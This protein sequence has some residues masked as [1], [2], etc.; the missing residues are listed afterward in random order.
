MGW[1]PHFLLS[2]DGSAFL[3]LK[4]GLNYITIKQ[5]LKLVVIASDM[6]SRDFFACIFRISYP[7]PGL[8][9]TKS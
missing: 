4:I 9:Y 1:K 6:T 3:A 7:L 5:M 2:V 8:S